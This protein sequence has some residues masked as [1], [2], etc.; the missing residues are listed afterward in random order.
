MIFGLMQFI[1][2]GM[3]QTEN[4]WK[5]LSKKQKVKLNYSRVKMNH[6]QILTNFEYEESSIT[7]PSYKDSVIN[8]DTTASYFH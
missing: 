6:V 5:I 1:G 7:E 8:S 2:M 3:S 4:F